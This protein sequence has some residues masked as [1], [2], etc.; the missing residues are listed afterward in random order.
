MLQSSPLLC[1]TGCGAAEGAVCAEDSGLSFRPCLQHSSVC[2]LVS[3]HRKLPE[4]TCVRNMAEKACWEYQGDPERPALLVQFANGRIQTP[5]NIKFTL[6]KNNANEERI[7][8]AK[9]KRLNYVGKNFTPEALKSSSLCRYYVGVRNK[10]TGKMQVFDAEQYS[11]QPIIEKS[12]TE[13]RPV[14]DTS[15]PEY[16]SYRE[17]IDALIEAFGTNKQ[18]RALSSRKMN[19]VETAIITQEVTKAADE[20]IEKRGTED[21]LQEVVIRKEELWYS[22]FLPQCYASAKTQEDVYKFDE[23]ISPEEY[24]VLENVAAAFKNITPEEL[25]EKVD[26]QEYSSYVLKELQDIKHAKDIDR[27]ARALWYIELLMKICQSKTLKRKELF[28]LGC[29]GIIV[30]K[31][32]KNFTANTIKNEIVLNRITSTMKCKIMSH[33]VALALHVSDFSVDLTLLQRDLKLRETRVLE[34]AKA[35]RLR[36]SSRYVFNTISSSERHKFGALELPLPIY[37]PNFGNRRKK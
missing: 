1:N 11:M 20:I 34:I 3:I 7:L 10:E 22:P 6:Y 24:A 21:L 19:K 31:I 30:S 33:V 17:K 29:P 35:M 37:K 27:Q 5:E 16:K 32:M 2:V 15:E 13:D 14:K 36:I 18:K 28:A 4:H 12:S 9:T 23:L 26:K 8:R 25:Q